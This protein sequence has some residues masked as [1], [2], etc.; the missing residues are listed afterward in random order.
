MTWQS[1]NRAS[2]DRAQALLALIP[3]LGVVLVMVG[4]VMAGQR[5]M[6]EHKARTMARMERQMKPP[7]PES[8]AAIWWGDNWQIALAAV[9]GG[10]MS[11]YG[12]SR[13]GSKGKGGKS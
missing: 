12:K 1:D 8:A 7:L 13:A 9:A 3:I 4:C 6:I 2:C 11:V 10:L 5:G